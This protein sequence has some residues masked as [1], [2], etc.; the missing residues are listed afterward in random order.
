M[1]VLYLVSG[2]GPPAGWGTEFI[3]DLIFKLSKKD[4]KVTIINPIYKH[5]RPDWKKWTKEQENKYGIKIIS[6]NMPGLIK[7]NLLLHFALTPLFVTLVVIKILSKEK[8][9][10]VHEFSSTPI[11]LFRSFLLKLLF[12][13]PTIFTLSVYNNTLLGKLFWFKIFDF[14]ASYC[15]PSKEII[16]RLKLL[17]VNQN[18]I[19]FSPPGI[20]LTNF[21]RVPGKSIARKKLNLP[22]GKK[23]ICFF[24]SLTK[25]KGIPDLLEAI[26]KIDKKSKN[27]LLITVFAIWK[28][29]TS[30]RK[31]VSKI[32]LMR[33]FIKL[34]EKRV[35]IPLAIAASDAVVLPQR[36]GHGTT[37]PPISTLE[38]LASKT[39]LITTDIIGNREL[40]TAP[41][42]LISPKNPYALAQSIENILRD[43]GQVIKRKINLKP[44]DI[45]NIVFNY[46]NIYQSSF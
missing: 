29:S 19:F 39:I 18:K 28:G 1:K 34:F 24:G 27:K 10:L 14:A 33:P 4:V 40:V 25:E 2:I 42:V 15:I 43:N 31:W 22:Q 35:S 9:N 23:I 46:L 36:T 13:T 41:D 17:G 16:N 8:F 44:Y 32:T 11:I 45:N 26:N 30:H 7:K 12:K 37:I 38:V 21:S 20:E 6:L 3:Q 5:T